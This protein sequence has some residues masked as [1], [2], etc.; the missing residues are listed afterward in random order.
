MAN[1]IGK[2]GRRYGKGLGAETGAI[3]T[4][5]I[6]VGWD[7]RAKGAERPTPQR[8]AGFIIA[9]NT[10]DP[11]GGRLIDMDAMRRLGHG[12]E[13]KIREAI[14]AGIKAPPG[15]LP[16]E[17]GVHLLNDGVWD[18]DKQEWDYPMM[19]AEQYKAMDKLG[20]LCHGDGQTAW[21]RNPDGSKLE[22]V[23]NPV[24]KLGV[25]AA[26]FCPI[27]AAKNC[28]PKFWLTVGLHYTPAGARGPERL[29]ANANAR[30]MLASGS[31]WG[32][33]GIGEVLDA[34]AERLRYSLDGKR[35]LAWLAGLTGTLTVSV[36]KK[37]YQ[38]NGTGKVGVTPQVR[39]FLNEEEIRERAGRI[40]ATRI[41]VGAALESGAGPKLIEGAVE[42]GPVEVED[43]G[44][45]GDG[46]DQ[47]GGTAPE[48]PNDV[49][50][51]PPAESDPFGASEPAGLDPEAADIETLA[52]SIAAYCEALA[53]EPGGE[54]FPE[55]SKRICEHVVHGVE[56]YPTPDPM[57][58]LKAPATL[59][60]ATLAAARA[61]ARKLIASGDR[62]FV[63]APPPA[64][65]AK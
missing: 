36:D 37:R 7:V 42:L 63:L 39:L 44:E 21:R 4:H 30:A 20:C 15:L 12:D 46:E 38:E 2:S 43:G 41:P 33:I 50:D 60:A 10:A 59:R 49:A 29:L 11:D 47:S 23:C 64:E 27:S 62:R 25:A 24:G 58:W 53:L 35:E 61:T 48:P 5:L 51:F 3:A 8:L 31:D 40:M 45:D 16:R 17:L 28:A 55:I 57:R 34:A 22:V 56:R 6:K 18:P 1:R 14:R 13:A 9:H 26:D 32:A 52:H 65:A 19:F 54:N